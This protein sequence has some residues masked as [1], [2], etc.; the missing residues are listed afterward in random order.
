MKSHGLRNVAAGTGLSVLTT[1]LLLQLAHVVPGL[2]MADRAA[3]GNAGGLLVLGVVIALAVSAPVCLV[4]MRQQVRIA[5]LHGELAQAF[6][7]LERMAR[8]DGMTGLTNRDV[9]IEMTREAMEERAGWLIV[10]DVDHFKQINDGFGHSVGD[11]VLVAIGDAIQANLRAGDLCG[12]LGGE[13]FGLFLHARSGR[14]A[15]AAAER[16]RGTVADLAV[17]TF[18]G[19]KVVP[20]LSLGV[21]ATHGL[22][23]AE[24]MRRADEALYEAKRQGRNRTV[25][26]AEPSPEHHLRLVSGHL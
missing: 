5:A 17:S 19:G 13:E 22:S 10:A 1:V 21:S 3:S 7:R 25:S 11:R 24:A 9:F 14:E 23:L 18:S 4:L 15:H 12:R 8:V 6:K 26:A 20:T 16:L 2:A